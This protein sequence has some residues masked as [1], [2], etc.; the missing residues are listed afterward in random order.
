LV[1]IGRV[2]EGKGIDTL[3]RAVALLKSKCLGARL[4]IVGDGPI[5]PSLEH[6]AIG[7]GIGPQV[8]FLGRVPTAD[9]VRTLK[10]SRVLALCSDTYIEGFG[11]VVA[12]ALACGKPVI[13]SNQ[14]PLLETAG[15]AGLGVPAGDSAEVAQAVQRLLTEPMF[16]QELA[17]QARLRAQAFSTEAAG[18][19]T[20][21][22]LEQCLA[23]HCAP[24]TQAPGVAWR[25]ERKDQAGTW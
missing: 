12:E 10:Q 11:I 8:S 25:Q 17:N 13:V 24:A 23:G 18:F 1:Y 5:R 9:L 22:Y 3:I 4:A 14:P 16:Y 20:L 2:I 19:Q 6:L 15:G 7:L 21:Q